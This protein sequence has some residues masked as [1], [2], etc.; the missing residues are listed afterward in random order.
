[1][2]AKQR[3][4]KDERLILHD[5]CWASKI[6]VI[7]NNWDKRNA[8]I[9]RD[10]V[11]TYRFYDPKYPK[12][13]AVQ[14]RG[15]N[16]F[17]NVSD[18]QY[19]TKNIINLIK[20]KLLNGWNPITETYMA[21]DKDAVDYI[22]SPE[23]NW[24][25][26]LRAAR[27]RIAKVKSTGDDYKWVINGM[28][29]SA[30]VL[31]LE[32]KKIKDI[33][34][35]HLIKILDNC[36]K[37]NKNFTN[38]RHNKY[39]SY[40][41]SLFKE[42]VRIQTIDYNPVS[43]IEIKKVVKKAEKRETLTKEQRVFLNQYLYL[44]H[45]NF[46]RYMQIFFHSGCRISETMRIQGKHVDITRS[47]F[48]TRVLKGGVYM[49]VWRPIKKIAKPYWAELMKSCNPDDYLFSKGLVPGKIKISERQ[50]TRRWKVHVKDNPEVLQF[51]RITADFYSLK[52]TNT[53]E[54]ANILGINAAAKFNV[55]SEKMIRMHYDL[56]NEEREI[57]KIQNMD[58]Q[59]A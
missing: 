28:E 45:Y 33:K 19:V 29:K 11:I 50:I 17:K 51:H 18:R 13:K 10:W 40:L 30:T 24:I 37:I 26:A 39:R 43:D 12:A 27:E 58:N 5:G 32:D 49:E 48:R 25:K 41:L 36:F 21:P 59:F 1:M 55:E 2:A 46:W 42:L 15:M 47:R 7:P 34:R 14:V 22:I 20:E 53:T 44:N 6:T 57:A 52:H 54:I 16:D 9:N 3:T 35:V 23:M 31:R 8:P 38:N 4:Q 56:D